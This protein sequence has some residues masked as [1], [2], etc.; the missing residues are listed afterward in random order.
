MATG[1]LVACHAAQIT[2]TVSLQDQLA[3]LKEE[4]EREVDSVLNQMA[5]ERARQA[6]ALEQAVRRRAD[7]RKAALLRAQAVQSAQQAASHAE[8]LVRFPCLCGRSVCVCSC[9]WARGF[10][11]CIRLWACKPTQ[12]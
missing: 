11:P 4:N 5:M 1:H 3:A 2:G 12:A 10:R 9:V 8:Q 6:A 7:Q